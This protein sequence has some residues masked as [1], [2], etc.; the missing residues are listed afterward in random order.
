ML[1]GGV[2]MSKNKIFIVVLSIIFLCGCASTKAPSGWLESASDVDYHAWGGWLYLEV[3]PDK[4]K[5]VQDYKVNY[6]ESDLKIGGGEFIT[7]QDSLVYVINNNKVVNVP[8]N[9]I[10][11]A[12]LEIASNKKMGLAIWS[13]LGF[14]STISHGFLLMFSGPAWMIFGTASTVSE[15]NR[16]RFVSNTPDYSWWINAN[17]FSRFPQ[18]LP[19]NYDLSTLKSKVIKD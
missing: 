18:G 16:N 11:R 6:K 7:F 13:S 1:F 4:A 17:K 3:I 19:K 5:S 8:F 14:L 9:R 12:E 15:S 2:V 10:Y